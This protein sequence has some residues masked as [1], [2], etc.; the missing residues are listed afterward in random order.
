MEAWDCGSEITSQRPLR[1]SA[2]PD[3]SP[4]SRK[5]RRG[6]R[7]EEKNSPRR[8]GT[9]RCARRLALGTVTTTGERTRD[10]KTR[11]EKTRDEKTRDEKTR[12][13]K[14]RDGKT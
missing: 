3:Y 9:P 5:G 13:G 4:Q 11:D 2:H 10:E 14:T 1:R 6:R 7:G 8:R 12:D